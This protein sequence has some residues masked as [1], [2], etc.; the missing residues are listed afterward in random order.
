MLKAKKV[1]ILSL[2]ALITIVSLAS[3]SD[4]PDPT[5]LPEP[6]INFKAVKDTLGTGIRIDLINI[7][8]TLQNFSVG[9]DV[10]CEV[11][12]ADGTLLFSKAYEN[13]YEI[14]TQVSALLDDVEVGEVL[15]CK[16]TYEYRGV[17]TTATDT[18]TVV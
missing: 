13:Q 12:G 16:V 17:T 7:E 5:L 6:V 11:F 14:V 9:T 2:L 8:E 15:T 4:G 3:C 10:L 1:I 18:D